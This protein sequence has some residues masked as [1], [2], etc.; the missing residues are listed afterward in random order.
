MQTVEAVAHCHAQNVYHRDLKPENI[1]LDGADNVK[2]AD[3]GLAALAY[4]RSAPI[5][6]TVHEDASFLQ[7]TKCGSLMYAAPEVLR[8]T[9]QRGY[10][11]AAADV[12]SLGVILFAMLS[13]TLPFQARARRRRHAPFPPATCHD[14]ARPLLAHL[15]PSAAMHFI[16][17]AIG[18]AGTRASTGSRSCVFSRGC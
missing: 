9:L 13:G 16:A 10:D 3:F 5:G 11:A 7:H 18:S 14:D 8:T 15:D 12:W 6:A 2:I 4:G 1:L 17:H